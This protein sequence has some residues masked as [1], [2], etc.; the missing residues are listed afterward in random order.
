MIGN[1]VAIAGVLVVAVMGLDLPPRV[2]PIGKLASPT[3]N[4]RDE[5]SDRAVDGDLPEA[6]VD[7]VIDVARN[8][9]F[10]LHRRPQFGG[11]DGRAVM[12]DPGRLLGEPGGQGRIAGSDDRPAVDE[13]LGADL[14]RHRL[15][16]E[17]HRAARRR[18]D[19]ALKIEPCRMFG[20]I[21]IAAPP[22]NRAL[23]DDVVEPGLADLAR[24]KVWPRAVVLE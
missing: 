18:L 19:P 5:L 2:A 17:R 20:G 4:V 15:A 21:A 14:F 8:E 10:R 23:L 13:N 1:D 6:N 16:V 3:P 24:G 12:A 11:V 22:K 9:G 7:Q